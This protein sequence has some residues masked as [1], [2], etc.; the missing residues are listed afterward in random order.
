MKEE[1]KI[2]IELNLIL[3]LLWLCSQSAEGR[4]C[5]LFLGII[6]SRILYNGIAITEVI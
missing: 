3:E 2:Y 5:I 6:F 4:E 1:A